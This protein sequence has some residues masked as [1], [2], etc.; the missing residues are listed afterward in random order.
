MKKLTQKLVKVL[1][2]CLAILSLNSCSSDDENNYASE[3]FYEEFINNEGFGSTESVV[4]NHYSYEF[5]L[6]FTP[7]VNGEITHLNVKIPEANSALRVTIWDATTKTVLRTETVNVETGATATEFDITDLQLTKDT[8]YCISLNTYSYYY[9]YLDDN[10]YSLPITVGNIQLDS[11]A[12]LSGTSQAYPTGYYNTYYG[13][14]SFT[15]LQN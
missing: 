5:G 15:F 13:N 12:Y 7:L 10:I 14:V 4:N 2:F 1:G 3:T 6:G 11:F 8:P 9:T